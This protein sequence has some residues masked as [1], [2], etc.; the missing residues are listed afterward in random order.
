MPGTSTMSIKPTGNLMSF[1][2]RLSMSTFL[3]CTMCFTSFFI[4]AQSK[5]S[6]SKKS[7]VMHSANLCGPGIGLAM[8]VF[9]FLSTCQNHGMF[10]LFKCLFVIFCSSQ[11]FSCHPSTILLSAHLMGVLDKIFL[12]RPFSQSRRHQHKF[13]LFSC[14]HDLSFL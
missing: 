9:L 14:Q 3:L 12:C 10:I 13:L 4:F 5:N 11:F 8:N 6:R 2:A 7:T 1:T